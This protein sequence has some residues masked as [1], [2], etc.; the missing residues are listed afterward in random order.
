M[1]ARITALFPLW[2]V[3]ACIVAYL[4]PE[5]LAGLG[6]TIVPLLAVIMFGMGLTLRIGD[7]RRVAGRPL[8][9]ALGTAL[10]FIVMPLAAYLIDQETFPS[11]RKAQVVVVEDGRPGWFLDPGT[12]AKQSYS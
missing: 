8:V 9:V 11:L 3:I 4:V 10:Q 2:A 6:W 7:F 1:I 12:G 5:P